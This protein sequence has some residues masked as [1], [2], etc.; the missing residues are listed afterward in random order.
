MIIDDPVAAGE[1]RADW[2]GSGW[3]F[4]DLSCVAF[5]RLS[6][7]TIPTKLSLAR[8][9]DA[10]LRR[11]PDAIRTRVSALNARGRGGLLVH[12]RL[13]QDNLRVGS[14]LP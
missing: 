14:K 7:R 13:S 10:V 5:P 8:M 3:F 6:D 11:G 4:E 1:I 2:A 9:S 12:R